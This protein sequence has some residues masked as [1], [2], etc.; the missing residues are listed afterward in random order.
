MRFVADL[1]CKIDYPFS[2][3]LVASSIRSQPIHWHGGGP[4]PSLSMQTLDAKQ[5]G[6]SGY[7]GP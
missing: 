2:P 6:F 1:A 4:D 5:D 7:I 3:S